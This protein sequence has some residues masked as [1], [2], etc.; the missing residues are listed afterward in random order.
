MTEFSIYSLFILVSLHHLY[1]CYS[2]I[3]HSSELIS[4][5]SLFSVTRSLIFC[6]ASASKLPLWLPVG[7]GRIIGAEEARLVMGFPIRLNE[8]EELEL[9]L[10][11]LVENV[12]W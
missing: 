5:S 9:V 7:D 11:L 1:V 4:R 2:I 12:D 6:L 3:E 8:I 10:L